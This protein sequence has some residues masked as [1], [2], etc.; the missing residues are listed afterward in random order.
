MICA[1]A[2]P[3]DYQER[4][5]ARGNGM[6]VSGVRPMEDQASPDGILMQ[7]GVNGLLESTQENRKDFHFT[8]GVKIGVQLNPGFDSLGIG[9]LLRKGSREG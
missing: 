5:T 9:W 6:I 8:I 1:F 7:L 4:Q 3:P 2:G